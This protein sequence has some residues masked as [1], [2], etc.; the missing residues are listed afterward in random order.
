MDTTILQ[1]GDS[2]PG[3]RTTGLVEMN[4]ISERQRLVKIN[5]SLKY[6]KGPQPDLA[7]LQ[8]H[9]IIWNPHK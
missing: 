1:V 2:K 8:V 3:L 4:T 7:L 6:F 9:R 5:L